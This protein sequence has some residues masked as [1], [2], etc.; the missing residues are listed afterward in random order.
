MQFSSEKIGILLKALRFAAEKHSRQRRK[1][2]QQTPYINHPV[3]VAE[4]LWNVG[5]EEDVPLI[6][7]ALLHDT[8][9]DTQTS[10]EEIESLFGPE[11]LSLVL[12]VTD[13]KNL[14]KVER[15][16]LQVETAPHKSL[17]AKRLKLADKISNISDIGLATP[18]DWTM[19][20]KR[21]Y[22][23]WAEK[24]IAGLKGCNP[25]LEKMFER[26]LQEARVRLSHG[27]GIGDGDQLASF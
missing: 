7:A 23:D 10:P 15:K 22:L 8:I 3:L 4:L 19:K 1:D 9:E 2:P 6:V 13:D 18:K 27:G 12:E 24:V 16:R 21:E 5:K 26:T 20:R 17:R 11:V 25:N 14:P